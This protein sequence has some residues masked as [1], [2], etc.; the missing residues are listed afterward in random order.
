MSLRIAQQSK[1]LSAKWKM[2]WRK[3]ILWDYNQT[4]SYELNLQ[5]SRKEDFCSAVVLLT[6]EIIWLLIRA[7]FCIGGG[8]GEGIW[9]FVWIYMCMCLSLQNRNYFDLFVCRYHHWMKFLF[10]IWNLTVLW[11]LVAWFRI[12]LTLNFTTWEFMSTITWNTKTPICIAFS[13][14]SVYN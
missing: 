11:S 5:E 14:L 13:W 2:F 10:L 7:W 8:V 9:Q 4:S 6:V 1:C 3:S 12:C